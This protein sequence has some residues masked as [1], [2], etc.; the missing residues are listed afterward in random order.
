MTNAPFI[1]RSDLAVVLNEPANTLAQ[2]IKRG[3]FSL[4]TA[5]CQQGPG[6]WTK[7]AMDDVATLALLRALTG[8]GME[9]RHASEA[10]Q[11]AIEAGRVE[12]TDATLDDFIARW[13]K[14]RLWISRTDRSWS[15]NLFEDSEDIMHPATYIVVDVARIVEQAVTRARQLAKRHEKRSA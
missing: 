9:M 13:R 1:L 6:N 4:P 7:F 5:D 14:A 2:V 11:V 3:G 10:V 8:L 15:F 12:L